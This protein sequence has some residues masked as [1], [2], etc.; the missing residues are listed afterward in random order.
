MI[1]VVD[2]DRGECRQKIDGRLGTGS[3]IAVTSNFKTVAI[4]SVYPT[5][6]QWDIATRDENFPEWTSTGHDADVQCLAY[7]PDGRT[8]AS[9]GANKQI[10]LWDADT[11]KLRLRLPS[12]WSANRLAFTPSGRNLLTS[13]QYAGIIHLWDAATGKHLRTIDSGMNM[14]RS[15]ALTADGK[16][17]STAGIFPTPAIYA[18]IS[19]NLATLGV[20]LR[21]R[22][23]TNL[24]SIPSSSSLMP[25]EFD[26]LL[27]PDEKVQALLPSPVYCLPSTV[28]LLCTAPRLAWQAHCYFG[29]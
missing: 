28:Y 19:L 13:W 8:I 2:F 26:R 27:R 6:R 29:S 22:I 1:R 16:K 3:S 11:G 24:A 21:W 18:V 9:G 10:N 23:G 15:F 4:G 17:T 5:I 25:H 7:S 12:Q 20:N 14:V